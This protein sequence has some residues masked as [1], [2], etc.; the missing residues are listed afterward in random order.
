MHCG[1]MLGSILIWK[2]STA[3]LTRLPYEITRVPLLYMKHYGARPF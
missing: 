2:R 3:K 1:Q